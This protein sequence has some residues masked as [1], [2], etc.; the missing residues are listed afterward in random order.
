MNNLALAPSRVPAAVPAPSMASVQP[1]ALRQPAANGH[2]GMSLVNLSARQRMLS[3]RLTL[4][5][6]LAARGESSQL[7]AAEQSLALFVDSQAQL[8]Q[9]ARQLTNGDG[10][11]LRE[12]YFEPGH[13]ARTVD[14]FI[15]HAQEAL[16]Y[17]RASHAGGNVA[18][19][20][21][22]SSVDSVLQALNTA[23]SAFDRISAAKEAAIMKELKGIVG[24]I[25]S[26]A[27]EAKVVSFN[28]QVIAARAGTVGREFAVVAN[29]LA[30]I[31]TEV[32]TLA[33]K[34]LAL[35]SR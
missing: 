27:R 7:S 12:T 22:V 3:Q 18:L 33:K 26:V 14:T 8:V 4:Q 29:T 9:T 23:T 2:N 21:L 28:A 13:V 25:Q 30:N 1:V 17:A 31:S 20:R 5:I 11:L 10:A 6:V 24:D 35:A 34:G 16:A 15:R 19:E 32:D